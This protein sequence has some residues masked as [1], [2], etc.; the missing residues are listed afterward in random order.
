MGRQAGGAVG[1]L[2]ALLMASGCSGMPGG[3][4]YV[5]PAT[6]EA[7]GFEVIDLPSPI[8][9]LRRESPESDADEPWHLYIEGDGNAW[10]RGRATSNPTPRMP[11]ATYLALNDD[12]ARIAY[13]GRP[14]QWKAPLP[15]VC[16]PSLWTINRYGERA[17]QWLLHAIRTVSGDSPVV[18]VGFSGGAHLAVQLA[19]KLP[20]LLGVVSV[21]G[22]LNDAYF[23]DFH[24]LPK[25]VH[26]PTMPLATPLWSLSGGDDGVIPPELSMSMLRDHRDICYSHRVL[27]DAGHA[28]PWQLDWAKIQPF[29]AACLSEE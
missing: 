29:M 8:T 1:L 28:G 13:I 22:N 14:C 21:A 23:A 4:A 17:Q 12:A 25:P 7:A 16:Q 11:V 2:S 9:A 24:D 6:L 27:E 3:V 5:D 20:N 26:I 15:L 18:L 10:R 19:P